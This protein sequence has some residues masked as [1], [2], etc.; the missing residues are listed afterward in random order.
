MLFRHDYANWDQFPDSKV[1]LAELRRQ[2]GGGAL[3]SLVLVYALVYVH[4][5][6]GLQRLLQN[7]D[8]SQHKS[9]ASSAIMPEQHC[10]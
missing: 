6:V 1:V 8:R 5:D 9:R 3:V 2:V 10:T 7:F 4:G